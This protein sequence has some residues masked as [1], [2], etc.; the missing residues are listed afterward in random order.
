M[1]TKGTESLQTDSGS[2]AEELVFPVISHGSK[3]QSCAR[4]FSSTAYTLRAHMR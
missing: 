1:K 4:Q 2:E 3:T